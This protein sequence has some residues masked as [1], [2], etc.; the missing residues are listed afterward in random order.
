[1]PSID[2]KFLAAINGTTRHTDGFLETSVAAGQR[3]IYGDI[4]SENYATTGNS[5]TGYTFTALAHQ[6]LSQA[7]AEP[8]AGGTSVR[9]TSRMRPGVT[10]A[11]SSA[12]VAPPNGR[13]PSIDSHST[14]HSAK[15]SLRWSASPA[16]CSG[17]M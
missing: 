6:I 3:A 9:A 13:R 11:I 4:I 17:A 8:Y 1:M 10:L 14:T 7:G 5:A 12:R 2:A 16:N 15:T